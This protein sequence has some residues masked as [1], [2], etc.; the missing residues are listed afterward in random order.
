MQ[1]LKGLKVFIKY[2]STKKK[3]CAFKSKAKFIKG[4]ELIVIKQR[5]KDLY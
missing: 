5:K 2:L 1:K 3:E 4:V